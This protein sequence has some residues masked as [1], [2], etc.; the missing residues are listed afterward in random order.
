M[1]TYTIEE[2]ILDN[3]LVTPGFVYVVRDGKVIFYVGISQSPTFRICQHVGIADA[4]SLYCSPQKFIEEM[5]TGKT[6]IYKLSCSQVG[7]CIIDNAPDSLSWSFDIYEKSDA[8]ETMSRAGYFEIFPNL[9]LLMEQ[10]WYDQ[11]TLVEDELIKTL[12]PCL[13]RIGNVNGTPLPEKYYT[14]LW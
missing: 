11:R 7:S 3:S 9:L 12:K 6:E 4:H 8:I 10:D 2:A 13:N 5:G 14:C 1:K